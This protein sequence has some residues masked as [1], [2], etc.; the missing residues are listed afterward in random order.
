MTPT[1][2]AALH[3][4]PHLSKHAQQVHVLNRKSLSSQPTEEHQINQKHARLA[5][6]KLSR[7]LPK[8]I[9]HQHSHPQISYD[10][11]WQRRVL[12]HLIQSSRQVSGPVRSWQQLHNFNTHLWLQRN[13]LSP[14]QTLLRS[15]HQR[16]LGPLL[17]PTTV[18]RLCA[19]PPHHW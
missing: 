14:Y 12:L 9:S 17:R 6:F 10:R 1:H 2:S 11:H 18:Q 5:A 3:M 16:L 13:P 15:I 7:C 19:H 8:P 4:S